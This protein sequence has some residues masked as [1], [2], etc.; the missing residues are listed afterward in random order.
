MALFK[1]GASGKKVVSDTFTNNQGTNTINL[2]FVPSKVFVLAQGSGLLTEF[3]YDKDV[4][5]TH[6]YGVSVGAT[7]G[8]GKTALGSSYTAYS[9]PYKFDLTAD[10]FTITTAGSN[11]PISYVAVE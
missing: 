2:G 1:C 10:G 9:V 6:F 4:D 8:G 7:G 3:Y 5:A 11:T